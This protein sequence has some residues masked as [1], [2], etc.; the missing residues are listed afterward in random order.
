MNENRFL[1]A[2][3]LKYANKKG[4]NSSNMEGKERKKI[5]SLCLAEIFF[6][7]FNFHLSRLKQTK[8]LLETRI[9]AIN[10]L[11]VSQ[12]L[13]PALIYL[14]FARREILKKRTFFW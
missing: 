2:F 11:D 6:V 8:F 14:S 3:A 12:C 10:N 9:L 4:T 13:L 5:A 1:K 7:F